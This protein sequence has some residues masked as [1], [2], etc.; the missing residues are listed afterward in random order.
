MAK[1]RAN[2]GQIRTDYL[3]QECSGRGHSP[4]LEKELGSIK[5]TERAL[6][7]MLASQLQLQA[8]YCIEECFI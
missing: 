5:P 7:Q 1:F 8:R 4:S 6:A 2:Y 3:C